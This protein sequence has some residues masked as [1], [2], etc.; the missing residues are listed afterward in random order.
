MI[1]WPEISV[2]VMTDLQKAVIVPIKMESP[3]VYCIDQTRYQSHLQIA[4]NVM[5][6][7]EEED[8]NVLSVRHSINGDQYLQSV[9]ETSYAKLSREIKENEDVDLSQYSAFLEAVESE[10]PSS[11][12]VLRELEA[13]ITCSLSSI[14][15]KIMFTHRVLQGTGLFEDEDHIDQTC[16]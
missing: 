10:L 8:Y 16:Q 3:K 15:S 13:D 2:R 9:L 11:V 1:E 7:S 5:Y 14:E 12:E 6:S 4:S